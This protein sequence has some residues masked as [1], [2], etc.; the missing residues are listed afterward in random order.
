MKRNTKNTNPS[1]QKSQKTEQILQKIPEKLL[2]NISGGNNNLPSNNPSN[3]GDRPDG[4]I[5]SL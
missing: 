4:Q 1:S 3:P 5:G 2:A